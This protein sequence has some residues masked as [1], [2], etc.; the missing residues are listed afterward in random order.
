MKIVILNRWVAGLRPWV[1]LCVT[2]GSPSCRLQTRAAQEMNSSGENIYSEVITTHPFIT[3][4]VCPRS[5]TQVFGTKIV[6]IFNSLFL[7]KDSEVK[8]CVFY[9]QWCPMSIQTSLYSNPLCP[10]HLIEDLNSTCYD[11]N[12][13]GT[14]VA[15]GGKWE[16]NTL[17]LKFGKCSTMDFT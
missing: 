5:L 14:M 2:L 15:L 16:Q 11:Q 12:N 1:D 13:W 6:Q 9:V 17:K 4:M 3:W 10:L 7:R 8:I